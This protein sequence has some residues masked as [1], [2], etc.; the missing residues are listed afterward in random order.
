MSSGALALN[1]IAAFTT[2]RASENGNRMRARHDFGPERMQPVLELRHHAEVATAAAHGPV[3][4]AV[5]VRV[6]VQ[7]LAVSGDDVD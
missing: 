2:L 4:I 6:G 3:E 5:L 1:S 7:K